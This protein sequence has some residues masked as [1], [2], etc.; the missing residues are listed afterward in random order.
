MMEKTKLVKEIIVLHRKLSHLLRQAAPDAWME[1]SLT[2]PQVKCLFFICDQGSTNFRKLA[3]ALKVTPS[4]ITG[5]IDRLVEQDLVS[6]TENPE[7]RRMMFLKATPKG[8]TLVS[9]LRE[10]KTHFLSKSLN[11]LE[12]EDLEEILRGFTLLTKA[13]ESQSDSLGT[14]SHASPIEKERVS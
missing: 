14:G 1:L 12:P 4:N 7:D 2:V 3:D 10:R 11:G 8:E 9:E 5:V 13:V 6:R